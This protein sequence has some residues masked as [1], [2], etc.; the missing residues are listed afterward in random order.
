MTMNSFEEIGEKAVSKIF[1]TDNNKVTLKILM[2]WYQYYF[3]G[4]TL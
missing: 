1:G 3:N 4:T 2:I